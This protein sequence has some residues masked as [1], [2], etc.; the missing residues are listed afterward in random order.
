MTKTE[1]L[2]RIEKAMWA[3]YTAEQEQGDP[4]KYRM[5]LVSDLLDEYEAPTHKKINGVDGYYGEDIP[6]SEAVEGESHDHK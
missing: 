5:G 4:V 6:V 2:Q 3:V 1:L